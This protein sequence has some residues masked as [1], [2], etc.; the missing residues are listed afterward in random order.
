VVKRN[1]R[2]RSTFTFSQSRLNC[3]P[4]GRKALADFLPYMLFF[5]WQRTITL[6]RRWHRLAVASNCIGRAA[7]RR[8]MPG[9]ILLTSIEWD[10]TRQ[11]FDLIHNVERLGP[12]PP[13]RAAKRVKA[14]Q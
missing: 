6:R 9:E 5:G 8:L 14:S 7:G 3:S 4:A 13:A 10:G 12:I 2:G 1:A 11:G